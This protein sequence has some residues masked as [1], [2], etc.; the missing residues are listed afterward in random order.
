MFSYARPLDSS[1]EGVSGSSSASSE[2]AA[3][4][5]TNV[6]RI[7]RGQTASDTVNRL[8][9][10]R[11]CIQLGWSL[12]LRYLSSCSSVRVLLCQLFTT[13]CICQMLATSCTTTPNVYKTRSLPRPARPSQS[14]LISPFTMST[15]IRW[16]LP[17]TRNPPDTTDTMLRPLKRHKRRHSTTHGLYFSTM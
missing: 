11:R 1:L 14:L 4:P 17:T 12:R 10:S 7:L 5:T 16:H 8:K 13:N 6:S 3:D 15:I 9:T 2:T